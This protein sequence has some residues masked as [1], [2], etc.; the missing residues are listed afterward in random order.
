MLGRVLGCLPGTTSLCGWIGPCPA[1]EISPPTTS[2]HQIQHIRLK[3]RRVALVK[4]SSN[5]DNRVISIGTRYSYGANSIQPGEEIPAY[6][7]D[8][9]NDAQWAIPE[10]PVRQFSTCKVKAIQLKKLP[11]NI[12]AAT[13]VGA[14]SSQGDE[15]NTEAQYRASITLEL[16]DNKAPVT[17]TLYTNPVFVTPP[18]CY[19]GPKGPHEVHRRELPR[20]QKG[21]W[22][23]E[24]LKDHT[25]HSDGKEDVMV[26]KATG[27]YQSWTDEQLINDSVH[28]DDNE[29]VMV[30]NATGVGSEILAR[31]WCSERGKSAV[32]RRS[33]GPCYV[34]AY[35]LASNAGL[36]VGVLIWV[37]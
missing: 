16:D 4:C 18:P 9:Q 25:A 26:V 5:N 3:A 21:I 36:G 12:S 10:P 29:D 22:T 28:F 33:E 6:L 30:I 19:S 20:Y 15:A 17:F 11:L 35:R 31:A 27:V 34:C 14:G 24:Q 8:M 37:A 23:V 32:I 1:A 7:S 13:R 2:K